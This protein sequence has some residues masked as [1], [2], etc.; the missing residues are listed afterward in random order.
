MK[1]DVADI[2]YIP[3]EAEESSQDRY[4]IYRYR[5]YN[6]AETLSRN[7]SLTKPSPVKGS[8]LSSSSR[9][10]CG[11]TKLNVALGA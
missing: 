6:N 8:F 1:C 2:V 4:S 5:I 10:N 7:T 3:I 9:A 11:R